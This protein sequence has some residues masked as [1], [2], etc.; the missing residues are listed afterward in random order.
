MKVIVSVLGIGLAA[1]M[2]AGALVACGAPEPEPMQLGHELGDE[3]R[4]VRFDVDGRKVVCIVFDGGNAG[5][6]SCDWPAK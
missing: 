6:I 3:S 4:V 1:A 5:G 2:A